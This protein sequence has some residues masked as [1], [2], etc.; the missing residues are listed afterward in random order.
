MRAMR[1]WQHRGSGPWPNSASSISP[2]AEPLPRQGPLAGTL[3]FAAGVTAV[4]LADAALRAKLRGDALSPTYEPL[5]TLKPVAD[6][7]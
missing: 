1:L 6:G 7:V 3:L 4:A 5:D 2:S